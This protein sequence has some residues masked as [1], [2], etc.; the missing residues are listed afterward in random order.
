[1]INSKKPATGDDRQP[2]NQDSPNPTLKPVSAQLASF[3]FDANVTRPS[4]A[5]S[6]LAYVQSDSFPV[7]GPAAAHWLDS[8]AIINR[9][10]EIGKQKLLKRSPRVTTTFPGTSTQPARM[11]T[12]FTRC[13][14]FRY[15]KKSSEPSLLTKVCG[16]A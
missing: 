6:Y 3:K 5:E 15:G 16:S 9:A 2:E 1:M 4:Y 11:F 8:V 12:K 13:H 10:N 14:C 7:S